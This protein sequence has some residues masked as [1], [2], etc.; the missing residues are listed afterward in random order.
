M[1]QQH[2]QKKEM[3]EDDT[4]ERMYSKE[5]TTP[6]IHYQ[7][8]TCHDGCHDS[9]EEGGSVVPSTPYRPH[10]KLSVPNAPSKGGRPR[11]EYIVPASKRRRL[12]YE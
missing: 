3:A 8:G 10:Q 2:R 4:G 11:K 1:N 12:T 9:H 6:C 5:C 7:N